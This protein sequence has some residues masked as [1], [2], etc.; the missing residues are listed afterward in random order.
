VEIDN[1]FK[2]LTSKQFAY[3]K[4]NNTFYLRCVS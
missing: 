4:Q 1:A 2:I 3:N